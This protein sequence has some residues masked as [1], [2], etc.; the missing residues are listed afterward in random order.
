MHSRQGIREIAL[1]A[2]LDAG[3]PIGTSEVLEYARRNGLNIGSSQTP[4]RSIQAAVW[5]DIHKK[6]KESPFM[7]VGGGSWKRKFWVRPDIKRLPKKWHPPTSKP[8][9]LDSVTR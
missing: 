3:R 7:M 8:R 9:A 1:A 5:L 2:I 6:G 4:N